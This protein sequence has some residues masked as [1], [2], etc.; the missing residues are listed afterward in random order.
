MFRVLAVVLL[1]CFASGL[2]SAAIATPAQ[3]EMTT[4]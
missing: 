3:A 2:V 4:R 1:L